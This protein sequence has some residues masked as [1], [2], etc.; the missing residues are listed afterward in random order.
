[1]SN[2]TGFDPMHDIRQMASLI[3]EITGET[4]D[5]VICRLENERL[6]PGRTVA[7][8]FAQHGGPRYEW[9]PHLEAFY[10]STNAF[11]YELVVWNRNSLKARMRR[12]T[13]RH[14]R[15]GASRW[16]F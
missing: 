5:V 6:H 4:S 7:E 1:M 8:D 10:K 2:C 13:T 12:W 9:G 15:N 11:L 16:I 14:L 3:S